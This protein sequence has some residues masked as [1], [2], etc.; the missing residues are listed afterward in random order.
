[1]GTGSSKMIQ[2]KE[3]LTKKPGDAVTF[4]LVNKL[5]GT[6]KDSTEALEGAEEEAKL[7]SFLV[8]VREYSHAVKFKKF[9]AQKTAIDLR[10][11]HKDIL[12]DWNMELDRDNIIEALMSINGTAFA[13]A[14]ATARNA[15]LVDNAD[16]VLF[17][18]LKSNASSL[19]HATALATIDNTDDKLTPDAISLMK[20]IALTANPKIRPFKTRSSIGDTEA[21]VLF[22]HPLHVRDL[23]LNSTFVAA[24]REA[25]NRGMDNPLFTGADYMW[26]N[27]AIYTI[28]DIPTVSSGVTVAPAFLCGAQA[29]GMAWAMRPQTV[30]E[31]FDYKRAIGLAVKQWYKVEKLRF[32]TGT[33]DT[34]DYKDNGVVTGWFAAV[35][36]S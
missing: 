22:A 14:D 1:M 29:L 4:T 2:V 17:G 30:E 24:N 9:E 13:S 6:A 7:R 34:S 20:R 11:A 33:T 31:E 21:Y 3:D 19:V 32:G 5:S 36:D 12:M 35:A 8:R 16:R 18:K 25:R 27:V 23:A 15:W 10:Q 26:E 28:E